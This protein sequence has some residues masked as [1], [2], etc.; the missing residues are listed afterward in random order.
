MQ[1]SDIL[2]LDGGGTKTLLLRV[3]RDAS[4][5]ERRIAGGS[6]PFD[7]PEWRDVLTALMDGQDANCVSAAFGMAGYGES[8]RL[9]QEVGAHIGALC[10]APHVIC[11]DVDMACRGAFLGEAGIL[12]LSGTGSMAWGRDGRGETCRAGG[13]GSLFGDEGSAYWIGREALS[14]FSRHLDGRLPG[15]TGYCR[16]F[17]RLREWPEDPARWGAALQDW[18]AGLDEPRPVV[19]ALARDVGALAGSGCDVSLAILHRAADHLARH[20]EALR[21]RLGDENLA[22]SYAGGTMRSLVLRDAIARRCGPARAPALPPIG[23][24]VM[25]AAEH[26]GWQIDAEFIGRLARALEEAGLT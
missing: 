7:V 15:G 11:N 3:R 2:A 16:D 24:A 9:T 23:G 8:R 21:H 17:A 22:W 1:R 26:A 13:W 6:N 10:S 19:A 20:V 18:Y 5:A 12:L 14:L 25:A 4:I